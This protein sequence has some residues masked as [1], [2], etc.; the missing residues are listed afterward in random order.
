MVLLKNYG[1]LFKNLNKYRKMYTAIKIF[2]LVKTRQIFHET[3]H[4]L[5]LT[6][7][8]PAQKLETSIWKV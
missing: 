8:A 6:K 3:E 7:W 1:Y 2:D 5:K 4:N